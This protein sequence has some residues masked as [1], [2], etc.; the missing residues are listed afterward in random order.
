MS[1]AKKSTAKY[2]LYFIVTL[3]ITIGM[4]IYVPAWFWVALPFPITF[5][6]LALDWM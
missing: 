4:L 5:F 3:A 2:W 6:V 1:E